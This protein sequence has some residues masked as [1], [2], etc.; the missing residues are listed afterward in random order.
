MVAAARPRRDLSRSS[1]AGARRRELL[2][3]A[4][5][6][7]VCEA[8]PG[9]QDAEALLRAALAGGAEIVQL[10]DKTAGED[11]LERSGATFARVAAE[12]DA[13]FIVN[14]S[15]ALARALGADG[16]HLGQEDGELAAARELLGP[17]AIIGV[18]THSP[19]QLAEAA[20]AGIADYASV[21]PVWET[22]TKA[23][24]PAVGLDLVRHAAATAN[25]P[26]FAIGGIDTGNVGDVLDAGATRIA[27]VRAVR[28]AAD[29]AAV[30]R[31]LRQ[32]LTGRG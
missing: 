31:E 16:V 2:A 14:D 18:S 29:P 24:R 25:L 23:G 27:V 15:P 20:A 32:A 21:G 30:A 22:P 10:R 5:L 8:L 4:R 26:F 9:G 11:L 6:Y 28:D 7:F 17:E 1:D 3:E 12:H 13:L 19:A